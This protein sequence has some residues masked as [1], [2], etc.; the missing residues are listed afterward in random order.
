MTEWIGPLSFNDLCWLAQ[1]GEI[2]PDML[3]SDSGD[4]I[5]ATDVPELAAWCDA[6]AAEVAKV[7]ADKQAV[8]CVVPFRSGLPAL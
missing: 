3:V 7:K 2:K 1:Y 4:W 5:T 8:N 6:H